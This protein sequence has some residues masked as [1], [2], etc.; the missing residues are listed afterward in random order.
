MCRPY[1]EASRLR[2]RTST[3]TSAA[4]SSSSRAR[5]TSRYDFELSPGH[6]CSLR[7][8]Q[9]ISRICAGRARS[10]CR[11]VTTVRVVPC[12][13]SD[14]IELCMERL[15]CRIGE[16]RTESLLELGLAERRIWHQFAGFGRG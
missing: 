14:A 2:S 6:V 7:L 8:A 16:L 1:S 11:T 10:S 3:V 12:N 5:V 13:G 15:E 4:V 9:L